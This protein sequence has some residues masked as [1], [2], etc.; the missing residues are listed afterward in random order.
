M[1]EDNEPNWKWCGKCQGLF[2]SGNGTEGKCP[3]G[4]GHDG[5][6]SLNYHLPF[7]Q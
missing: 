4:E 7:T 1:E 2:F 6:D 3:A 5:S